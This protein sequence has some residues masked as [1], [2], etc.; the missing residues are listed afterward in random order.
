MSTVKVH[1]HIEEAVRVFRAS[2]AKALNEGNRSL[3]LATAR[4]FREYLADLS[5][6][7]PDDEEWARVEMKRL[8]EMV[9]RDMGTS[10]W[11]EPAGRPELPPLP[12]APPATLFVLSFEPGK[13]VRY[14]CRVCGEQFNGPAALVEQLGDQPTY[15]ITAPHCPRE[16]EHR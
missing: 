7:P 8:R 3:A 5:A 10:A 2:A 12:A 13:P 1:P 15:T 4:K 6:Y 11:D 16:G 14:H 9:V